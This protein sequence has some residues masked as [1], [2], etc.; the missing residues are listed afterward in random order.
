MSRLLRDLGW[1][2]VRSLRV[3]V[4]LGQAASPERVSPTGLCA[5][6]DDEESDE[7]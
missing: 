5:T 1:H 4:L 6:H 3:A 7:C 2:D